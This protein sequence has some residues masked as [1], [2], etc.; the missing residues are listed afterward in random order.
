VSLNWAEREKEWAIRTKMFG[1]R[2]VFNICHKTEEELA[3]IT[4]VQREL[5]IPLLEKA[6]GNEHPRLTLDFGCGYGRWSPIL[7]STVRSLVVACDPT[8]YLLEQAQLQ[9]ADPWVDYRLYTDGRIP[10]PDGDADLIWSCMVLSTVVDEEMFAHTVGEFR[11]VLKPGGLL[12]II[13]NTS[14][15]PNRPVVRSRWSISRTITEYQRAFAGI[16][17]LREVGAYTDLGEVN[18]V[19]VGRRP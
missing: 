5:L 10:L 18:S 2:A 12:F 16:A 9:N 13:D 6:I 19:L 14:G 17:P 4:R 15:P 7:A 8:S 1:T 11:R 3:E